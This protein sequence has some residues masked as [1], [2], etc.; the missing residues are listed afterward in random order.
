[1]LKI[2]AS[3]SALFFQL[4]AWVG[5]LKTR[6]FC[7][8]LVASRH[9]KKKIIF[10][11]KTHFLGWAEKQAFLHRVLFLMQKIIQKKYISWSPLA[12]RDQVGNFDFFFKSPAP[13]LSTSI[14]WLGLDECFMENWKLNSKGMSKRE[15]R[16]SFARLVPA[17]LLDRVWQ[18][19]LPLLLLLLGSK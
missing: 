11:L 10:K 9:Y 19:E 18:M 12:S 5:F 7:C 17:K 6:F 16:E 8:K 15:G 2:V 3:I 13:L 1:M 4:E 14:S